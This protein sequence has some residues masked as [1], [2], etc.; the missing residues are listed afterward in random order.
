MDQSTVEWLSLSV[1]ERYRLMMDTM[2]STY[3]T[4]EFFKHGP[5]AWNSRW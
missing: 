1:L 3:A 4:T 5:R 2:E